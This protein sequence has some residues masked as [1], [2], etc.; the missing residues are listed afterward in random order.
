MSACKVLEFKS[1]RRLAAYEQIKACVSSGMK[2]KLVKDLDSDKGKRRGA[3]AKS[4]MKR[5][6]IRRTENGK[7]IAVLLVA[8]CAVPLRRR[9]GLGALRQVI[10]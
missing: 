7:M 3:T 6:C 10:K 1:L 9:N 8:V 2:E 5:W 4:R